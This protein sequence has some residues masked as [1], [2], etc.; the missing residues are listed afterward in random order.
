MS[1]EFDATNEWMDRTSG[2]PNHTAFTAACWV[3]LVTDRNTF[4][5]FWDLSTG[6]GSTHYINLITASNGTDLQVRFNSG[7]GVTVIAVGLSMVVGTW[8]YVGLTEAQNDSNTDI[9]I[10]YAVEGANSFT[11]VTNS[12]SG[13]P[14]TPSVFHVDSFI[15]GN[16]PFFG[17]MAHL[18][19][20]SAVLTEDELFNEMQQGLPVRTANMNAWYPFYD[21]ESRFV[22][23][24]GNASTLTTGGAG[25]AT[26]H[27]NWPAIQWKQGRG[28]VATS[29]KFLGKS[30]GISDAS[31]AAQQYAYARTINPSFI[32]S[33]ATPTRV[34]QRPFLNKN[35]S[36]LANIG[37]DSHEL[38]TVVEFIREMHHSI[39]NLQTQAFGAQEL[40]DD[41]LPEHGALCEILDGQYI[42]YTEDYN[43]YLET[44]PIPTPSYYLVSIEHGLGRVPQGY[45]MVYASN[46]AAIPKL[47]I[48]GKERFVPTSAPQSTDSLLYFLRSGQARIGDKTIF[49]VY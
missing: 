46:S 47:L 23:F 34:K 13:S 20:W 5:T 39:E 32:S 42:Q 12:P 16:F 4:S 36:A 38:R 11:K 1:I 44:T 9:S 40:D 26:T 2:L 17:A 14:N 27:G 25:S 19:L 3:K 30:F 49:I 31:D 8:Y 18:K 24:S 28:R 15:A 21:A 6:S 45:I 37:S 35:L 10:Y 7:S 41:G 29:V 43:T 22:D 33:L 48:T